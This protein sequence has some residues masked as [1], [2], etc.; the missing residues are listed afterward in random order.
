MVKGPTPYGRGSGSEHGEMF[1]RS[2]ST[3]IRMSS[4]RRDRGP[5]VWTIVLRGEKILAI[6]RHGLVGTISS[7]QDEVDESVGR[8]TGWGVQ[9]AAGRQ[10][11]EGFQPEGPVLSAE[12]GRLVATS[13]LKQIPGARG[14]A[15]TAARFAD[16]PPLFSRLGFALLKT[17][18]DALTINMPDGLNVDCGGEG[19][20]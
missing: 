8:K 7:S 10:K 17:P 20:G 11:G 19:G 16:R 5:R 18:G 2:F 4:I 9:R 1:A 13:H 6:L 3:Q 15:R 14:S 12:A